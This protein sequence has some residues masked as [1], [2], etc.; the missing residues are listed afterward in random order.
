MQSHNLDSPSFNKRRKNSYESKSGLVE[1]N[2][3][4]PRA[5]MVIKRFVINR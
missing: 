4:S 3:E 1:E 2:L 5:V